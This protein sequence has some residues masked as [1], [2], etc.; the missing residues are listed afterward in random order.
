MVIDPDE[1]EDIVRRALDD[2]PER[3]QPFGSRPAMMLM[4]TRCL[5]MAAPPFYHG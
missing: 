4:N 3:F 2:L 1:F 5:G